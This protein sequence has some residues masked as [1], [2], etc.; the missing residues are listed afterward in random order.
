[1]LWLGYIIMGMNKENNS[2]LEIQDMIGKGFP[3][4]SSSPPSL[5]RTGEDIVAHP[6]FCR[7][8]QKDSPFLNFKGGDLKDLLLVARDVTMDKF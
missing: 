5:P 8:L 2:N 3:G 1:M 6:L 4:V 7:H